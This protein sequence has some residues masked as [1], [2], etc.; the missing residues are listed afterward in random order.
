MAPSPH[1]QPRRALLAGA[2]GLVG[3]EIV[4]VLLADAACEAV[5][6][7]GRRA[8][9]LADAKLHAITADFATLPALPAASEAY[10][11]LGTTI[12]VAG[13]QAAF[14]AVDFDAVLAFARAAQAAGVTR[15]GVVSA[16]GANAGSGVFYNRV[17]GEM[18]AVLRELR[19]ETLVIARP[20]LISGDRAALGQAERKAEGFGLAA[21]RLLAP[22]TPRALRPIAAA[23]IAA[24]LVA[25]TAN[26]PEGVAVLSSGAMNRP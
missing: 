25:A 7:V 14:R 23:R 2:S 5:H 3:R 15:L 6:A 24:A 8:P 26:G 11:A 19:F 18:E 10:V 16:M 20:S 4:S 13:S 17:K 22:L 12:A 21:M 1:R 9:P